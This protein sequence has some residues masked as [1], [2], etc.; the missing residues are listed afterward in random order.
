MAIDLDMVE[1]IHAGAAEM[2]VGN[3][4]AGRLDDRRPDAKAGAGAQHRAR[5][6]GDVGLVEREAEQTERATPWLWP[7]EP[8]REKG[9][10]RAAEPRLVAVTTRRARRPG[11]TMDNQSEGCEIAANNGPPGARPQAFVWSVR[12]P[13]GVSNTRI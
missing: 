11:R 7:L 6:L 1:I 5:V 2:A 12:A 8:S 3:R 9:K 10:R 13:A 4:K